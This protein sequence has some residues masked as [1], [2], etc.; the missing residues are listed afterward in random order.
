MKHIDVLYSTNHNYL[1]NT[2]ASILSLVRNSLL[3]QN[4]Y[5]TV[6]MI[7]ENLTL[8]DQNLIENVKKICPNLTLNVYKLEEYNIK[9][10]GIPDWQQ[11]QVANSRLFFQDILGDAVYEIDKLLYLDA[12]TIVVGDLSPIEN[13]K[14]LICAVEDVLPDIYA[15]SLNLSKYYNSGVLL[16]DVPNW[17]KQKTQEQIKEY[18]QTHSLSELKYPDQDILNIVCNQQIS[19][20]PKS[21]NL[22]SFIY[23]L[24]DHALK[25]YC[26]H[27]KLCFEDIIDAKNNPKILHSTGFLGVKPWMINRIHP[28]SDIFNEYLYKVDPNYE[29]K[30]PNGIKG[31]LVQCP[32][33]FYLLYNLNLYLPVSM[34]S[35]YS[36]VLPNSIDGSDISDDSTFQKRIEQRK[37][38][39][40]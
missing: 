21:Y 37:L 9:N 4:E 11:T 3:N 17:I 12:D 25:Q 20:L 39:R 30:K 34:N 31:I 29:A 19:D 1:P 32:K 24:K 18:I 23:A 26:N 2:L 38:I 10:Y 15:K 22:H 16:F 35:K 14:G 6:H 28:Y 8:R 5:F 7:I 33:L 40:K 13:M 27:R 36:G